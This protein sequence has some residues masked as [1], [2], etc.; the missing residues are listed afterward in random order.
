M[1]VIWYKVWSDLW[2]NKIRT[3]LAVLSIAAGVFAIGATFGMSEQLV[4]GMNAA[5]QASKPAHFTMGL[6]NNVNEDITNRLKKI[7]GV[8]DIDL[9][10]FIVIRYKINL[11]DEWEP[12][13]LINREDFEA[14]QYDLQTLKAG[15]WPKRNRIGIERLS[16]QHFNL[17]IGD[18][19]YLEVGDRP[20]ARTISGKLRH[21]FVPPPAFGGPAVFFADAEG[22]ELFDVPR[23]EF[24]QLIVR[25]SPY[26][27]ELAREVASEIKD[28]LSKERIGVAVTIYQDPA[29]HWGQFI[30]SGVNMVLQVLAIVSLGASVVL[31]FNTLMGVVAQQLDQIGMIKAI[32]GRRWDILKVYL[33]VVLVYGLLSLIVALPLGAILAFGVTQYLLNIFNIDY[34]EFQYSNRAVTLQ[35]VAALA[36][37][38]LASLVPVLKGV[39]ITVREAISTYGLGTDFGSNRIDRT[40]ET[41]SRR[42]LTAPYAVTIGNLFRRKGRLLLTQSVLILAG[43]M[44]LA[45]MSLS[46]SLNLTM[47]NIIA[48][49]NYDIV[50]A[51]DDYERIER[52]NETALLVDGVNFA[53]A[54]YSHSASLLKQGQR[55]RE[56]GLGGQLIG[57]PNGSDTFRPPLLV[58]GRW[59]RPEDGAAV[60][61]RKDT[62]EDN[63]IK[64]G[65]TIVLDLGNL[66]D[67]E[68][69]VVGFYQDIFNEVGETDP[70]YAN[71]DAVF[72][73]TKRYYRGDQ[74]RLR[75]DVSDA[76][77]LD[78]LAS[79]VKAL[80]DESGLDVVDST[81]VPTIRENAD[82]QFAI[83]INMMLV[84]AVIMAMVGGIGLM[85]A[86]SISVVERTREIGVMRAIGA[87]TPTLL[88]MFMLEG[89]LQGLI[90]WVVVVPI[91]FV[92]GRPMAHA[93][94][95]ALFDAT[96]DYQYNYSAVL[97]WLLIV[98]VISVAASIIP[99]RNAVVISVRE[100]LAYT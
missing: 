6:I 47:D 75:T 14:Q 92:L 91:S 13:W 30:I 5:H 9:G 96:L 72:A 79:E 76:D 27:P 88:G 33:S 99:A 62:A 48:K 59:L 56:A 83:V 93:L 98:L 46:T 10:S 32:G 81:T 51:F 21:N 85:G 67:D 90:S 4:E 84:L 64:V 71:L 35:I 61:I 74:V 55:L 20:K 94:G 25:V 69:Q 89:V 68:W 23:G 58:A 22:M 53:E 57:I 38:L 63:N 26:S 65:D 95:I 82:T 36:V 66:G 97:A 16:S 39:R 60:V 15:E 70:I 50:L 8:E 11:D 3:L 34:N 29:E 37:P 78:A 1:S 52:I 54:W 42:F 18:T 28:N 100:S 73:A 43:T 86:L 19:V 41:F 2:N 49:H 77:R 7:D 12:A 44:F 87:R 24:T 45:V 80:Y 17:D 31:V 40:I